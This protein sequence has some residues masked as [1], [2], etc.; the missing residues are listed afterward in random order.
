MELAV[1]SSK[2]TLEEDQPASSKLSLLKQ[3]AEARIYKSTFMGRSSIVKQRFK[4]AYRHP[5]LD[6]KLSHKRT[7]QEVR[8]IVKCRKAGI[9]T[10]VVYFFD[11]ETHSIHMEYVEDS[12]TVREYIQQIQSSG[13]SIDDERLVSLASKIGAT[14]ASMHSVDV[15]HGDL[16]TS[17]M[18]L[19][20][21]YE[22]SHLIMIDFGLSQIS[23]LWEDKGVDLY[24]LERAFLSSHPNTEELFKRVLDVYTEN[25][26]K[27]GDVMKKLEEV[28]QRGRKRVMV[29]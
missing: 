11:N 16:T 25:Y 6:A 26:K 22:E 2:S 15:I 9:T 19:R 17:N 4:K 18:L 12:L 24:V 21:P 10:P 28:R 14:L 8:T 3:G 7:G 20:Q 13:A 27:S 5:K 1:T 23:H 29:G